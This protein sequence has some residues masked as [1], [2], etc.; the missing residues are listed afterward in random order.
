MEACLQVNIRLI[1]GQIYIIINIM[2]KHETVKDVGF[3]P[4]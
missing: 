1:S 2:L 3:I 4:L